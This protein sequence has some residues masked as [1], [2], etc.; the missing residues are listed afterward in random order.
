[1]LLEKR[2]VV[3]ELWFFRPPG[4][5]GIA[6]KRCLGQLAMLDGKDIVAESYS[7]VA[8]PTTTQSP[9]SYR[10]EFFGCAQHGRASTGESPAAS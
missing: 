10:L 6:Q 3:Q 1:M 2:S 9:N 8:V 5:Q 4:G 7:V